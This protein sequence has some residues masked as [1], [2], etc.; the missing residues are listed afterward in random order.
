MR[1][2]SPNGIEAQDMTIIMRSSLSPPRP[3]ALYRWVLVALVLLPLGAPA[4]VPGLPFMVLGDWGK[5]NPGQ[6]AV[7]AA[8][9]AAADDTHARF[10][11]SVGDN[12]YPHGVS[13]RDDSQWQTSFEHVYTAPGLAV[14]WRPVFGNHDYRGSTSAQIEYSDSSTRWRFPAAHYQRTE[15]IDGDDTADFFYLDTIPLERAARWPHNLWPLDDA[16]YA[17]L[18]RGLAQSKATW[19]IVIGHHPV[20]S[21]GS[22]GSAPVLLQRLRPLF[23]KYG[24]DAYLCGHNHVLEHI[25]VNG[26]NYFVV[27]AGSEATKV[28]A[29]DGSR[30]ALA[31]LGFMTARLEHDR[32]AVEFVDSTGT[33][34]YAAEIRHAD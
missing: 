33:A 15:T 30:F 13:S 1:Q 6:H 23:E 11:V 9:G 24:V 21:G 14:P 34:L 5:A 16:Q 27:G 19:K 12:F 10:I 29:I 8:L 20:F 31:K 7:A 28:Q 22:H 18:E 17:W 32:M 2:A 3:P 25:V 26:V 4:E